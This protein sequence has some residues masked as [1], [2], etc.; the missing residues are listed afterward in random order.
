M[1]KIFKWF[2]HQKP[3]KISESANIEKYFVYQIQSLVGVT[4]ADFQSLYVATIER[5]AKFLAES[6][7]AVDS[8][9][10]DKILTKVILTLKRRR[11][12]LLPIGSDSE[13]SF[14]EREEWTYAIFI[15]ALFSHIEKTDKLSVAKVLIPKE[16][17][18]WLQRNHTL[19]LCWSAYLSES[20]DR[21][22]NVFSE[23]IDANNKQEAIV[24]EEDGVAP[25]PIDIDVVAVGHSNILD[26]NAI[27]FFQWIK[28]A[29]VN[30]TITI[31]E[32]DSF[33]H[34][35]SE[36]I[37]ICI[38]QAI[39]T[40]LK[41]QQVIDDQM[42]TNR[43]ITLI[44]EIKK[45]PDLVRSSKNSRIHSYY[46]GRWEDRRVFSGIVVLLNTLEASSS[47]VSINPQL[48]IDAFEQ[49]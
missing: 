8:I 46:W 14:R 7:Q 5:F 23:I 17:F 19:F 30:K 22:N 24:I 9:I 35:V 11:G 4:Q 45:Y 18:N 21:K 2:G 28:T 39:D 43:R 49:S 37:L 6:N 29:L 25:I 13:T 33:V 20:T 10:L 34:G 32:S 42:I 27:D 12:Y 31:N 47:V 48:T 15:A 3:T 44:K 16:G 41:T 1:K 36:G 38:P 40:F 26:L